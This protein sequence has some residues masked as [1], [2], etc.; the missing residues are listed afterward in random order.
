MA[1]CLPVRLSLAGVLRTPLAS[2]WVCLV[3]M[4]VFLLIR[5]LITS[6]GEGRGSG[7]PK[8]MEDWEYLKLCIFCVPVF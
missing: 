7:K 5:Q 2:L 8:E 6:P 3:G 1:L 4:V